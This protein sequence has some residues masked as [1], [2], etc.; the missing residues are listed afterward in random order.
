[1]ATLYKCVAFFSS[2]QRGWSETY[3][4]DAE[5]I[6]ANPTTQNPNNWGNFSAVSNSFKTII[7]SKRMPL[8]GKQV[9]CFA[10]RISS[11]ANPGQALLD[12]KDIP[13]SNQQQDADNPPSDLV[14]TQYTPDFSRRRQTHLRGIWD[15]IDAEGG[16]LITTPAWDGLFAG[17]AAALSSP[18][19]GWIGRS[20]THLADIADYV[21]DI[22]TG[23]VHFTLQ[24]N[25]FTNPFVNSTVSV[26][27]SGI[28]G[29]SEL[30]GSLTVKVNSLLTCTTTTRISV[31]PYSFGGKMRWN[32]R[33]FIKISTTIGTKIGSRDT[34]APL[35]Q[36]HGR[37]KKR[38][39]G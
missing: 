8:A 29:T 23:Q 10:V 19:W 22:D 36:P 18:G 5:Q 35:L 34:G 7:L 33:G 3:Y 1:M 37:A 13:A 4:V 14:C 28:N 15:V 2:G 21:Q 27:V 12:Y 24:A 9:Q 38:V 16:K 39:R 25:L 11:V 17:F 6:L 26:R 31:F 30:N 20:V 32:E